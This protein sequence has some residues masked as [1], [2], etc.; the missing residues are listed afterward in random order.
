MAYLFSKSNVNNANN[1][2]NLSGIN[3]INNQ[4]NNNLQQSNN[5]SQNRP[6]QYIDLNSQKIKNELEEY[7]QILKNI[8]NCNITIN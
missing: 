8:S 1:I 3:A 6:N 4:N 7:K 5:F 2:G